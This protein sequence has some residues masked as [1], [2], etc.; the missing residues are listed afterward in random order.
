MQKY[1]CA[2]LIALSGLTTTVQ[3]EPA[4]AISYKNTE[5]KLKSLDLNEILTRIYK[6]KPLAVP[7]ELQEISKAPKAIIQGK[8]EGSSDYLLSMLPVVTYKNTAG[9]TRY[10]LVMQKNKY[11]DGQIMAC[12]ACSA[13]ADMFILRQDQGQYYLVNSRFDMTDLP[14]GDGELKLDI[15]QVN[16]HIQPFGQSLMGSY[17]DAEFSGAGGQSS[18][19][20]YALLLPEQQPIQW[21]F[22]GDAGGDT[23]SFYADRPELAWTTTS[24]LKVVA[25]GAAYYPI[26]V[27]YSDVGAKLKK[28]KMSSKT[29]VFDAKNNRYIESK[30]QK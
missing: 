26:K 2:V 3:A 9:E 21:L 20:W 7:A 1:L 23:S 4:Q 8:G 24:T 19:G 10:L 17:H 5:V 25:N 12:R 13:D 22:I 30:A 6:T 14:G 27:T 18:S 29:F 11:F 16:K 28:P 15:A